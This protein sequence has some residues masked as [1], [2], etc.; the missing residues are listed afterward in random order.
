MFGCL[1]AC[2]FVRLCVVSLCAFDCVV[3]CLFVY[4]FDAFEVVRVVVFYCGCVVVCLSGCE[5]VCSCVGLIVG[6]RVYFF[7][8]V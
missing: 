4:V 1:C 3:A 2:L 5:L 8:R 7:V 6:A